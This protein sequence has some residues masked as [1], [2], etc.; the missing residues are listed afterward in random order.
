MLKNPKNWQKNVKL[1]KKI[2]IYLLNDTMNFNEIFRKNVTYD[3][4][5]SHQK[6]GL[7]PLSRK[8]NFGRTIEGVKYTP[9]IFRVKTVFPLELKLHWTHNI[10]N[11]MK[12][13]MNNI[14]GL[15]L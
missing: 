10:M 14:P 9:G 3:N 7:H 4:I 6:S 8:Y 1:L 12:I 11:S 13:S 2:F 5:K 15:F